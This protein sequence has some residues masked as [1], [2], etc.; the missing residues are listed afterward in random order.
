MKNFITWL[1]DYLNEIDNVKYTKEDTIEEIVNVHNMLLSE[2][3]RHYGDCT[4]ENITCLICEYQSFLDGYEKY[5][6]NFIKNNKNESN[7]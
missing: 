4:K 2:E 6:R 7:T 3:A 5:C 1:T